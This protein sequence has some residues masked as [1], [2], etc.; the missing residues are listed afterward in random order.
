MKIFNKK[1]LIIEVIVLILIAGGV[2]Y[3]LNIKK[4]EAK[5]DTTIS[6]N[7]DYKKAI[8]RSNWP[9]FKNEK[10][11]F[12]IEHPQDWKVVITEEKDLPSGRL[13]EVKFVAPSTYDKLGEGATTVKEEF[14][15]TIASNKKGVELNVF[16]A[17]YIK[18][19]S[20]GKAKSGG[21]F[22][23]NKLSGYKLAIDSAV[24]TN[25]YFWAKGD[26]VFVFSGIEDV[27]RIQTGLLSSF[28]Y[29]Q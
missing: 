9:R 28:E 22:S 5:S 20:L 25:N 4:E 2:I 10:F 11:G 12:G 7:E 29:I 18:K 19:N 6:S 1:W 17:G 24:D 8:V 26:Q 15:F 16:A 27:A 23:A 3:Y 14:N 13:F 21:Y